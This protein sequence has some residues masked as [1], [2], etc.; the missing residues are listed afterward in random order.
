MHLT[1]EFTAV[2]AWLS[3]GRERGNRSEAEPQKGAGIQVQEAFLPGGGGAGPQEP[4]PCWV[5]IFAEF[6]GRG[7]PGVIST[8]CVCCSDGSDRWGA[9]EI[10]EDGTSPGTGAG[11]LQTSPGVVLNQ[12]K[13]A[14][15]ESSGLRGGVSCHSSFFPISG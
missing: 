5:F 7:C 1:R 13:Q 15:F 9:R 4:S 14:R 11:A 6:V 12:A 2:G 3:L 10:G 8:H